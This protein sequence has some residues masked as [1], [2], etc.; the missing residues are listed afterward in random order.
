MSGRVEEQLEK[1]K[2]EKDLHNQ[3]MNVLKENAKKL[4]EGLN[5]KT[6]QGLKCSI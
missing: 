6:S 5:Q 2:D 1:K 4:R 3:G